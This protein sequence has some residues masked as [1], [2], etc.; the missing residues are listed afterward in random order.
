MNT[1][2]I[3]YF[4]TFGPC[5]RCG[6][7]AAHLEEHPRVLLVVHR[8]GFPPCPVRQGEMPTPAPGTRQPRQ[9]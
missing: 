2:S 4:H 9:P 8:D 1:P 5:V 3:K 6:R 7:I